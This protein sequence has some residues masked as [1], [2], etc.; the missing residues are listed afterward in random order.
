MTNIARLH[1]DMLEQE[2]HILE[3][4]E[5]LSDARRRMVTQRD[6]GVLRHAAELA[7]MLSDAAREYQEWLAYAAD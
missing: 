1:D 4:A 5:K 3:L 7:G 6:I 2:M